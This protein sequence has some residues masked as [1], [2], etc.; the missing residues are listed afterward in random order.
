MIYLLVSLI[1]WLG[2]CILERR[3]LAPDEALDRVVALPEVLELEKRVRKASGGEGGVVAFQD[4]EGAPGVW[5]VYVG[6]NHP[7]HTVRWKTFRV[8]GQTGLIRVYDVDGDLI[9]LETWRNR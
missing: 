1:P 3:P 6:E 7:T 5:D 2:C 8:D 9:S 4:G